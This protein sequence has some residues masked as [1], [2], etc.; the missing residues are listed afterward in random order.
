MTIYFNSALNGLAGIP[1][2]LKTVAAD[3]FF[4]AYLTATGDE[5]SGQ[6]TTMTLLSLES[7]IPVA[8]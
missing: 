5:T 2:L 4:M 8:G 6:L 1:K 3:Q 7:T